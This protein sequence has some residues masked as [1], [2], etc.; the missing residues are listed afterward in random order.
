MPA[1]SAS[2]GRNAPR[3]VDERDGRERQRL[4]EV[5]AVGRRAHAH[6]DEVVALRDD[7]LVDALRPLGGDEQVEAELPSFRRDL[8]R[9]LGREG[10]DLVRGLAGTDVVRLVDDDEDRITLGPAAPEGGQDALGR[11]RLFPRSLQRAEVDHEAARPSGSGEILDRALVARG[12][13]RPAVDA[14]VAE[15]GTERAPLR[16]RGLQEAV[17]DLA[18]RTT[19]RL[20]GPAPRGRRGR[21]TPPGRGSG[22][23]ARRQPAPPPRS[24]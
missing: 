10:G 3:P 9:A 12:P 13:D 17:G 19:R 16:I 6:E 1:T 8:R 4:R 14:E 11:D 21:R 5:G 15:A 18:R 23:A 2:P 7:E 22:R 24:R 20:R